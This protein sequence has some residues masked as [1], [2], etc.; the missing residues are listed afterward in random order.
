MD[1]ELPVAVGQRLDEDGVVEVA[2]GL[3]V[4]GDD[5]KAAEVAALRGLCGG[6]RIDG[7]CGGGGGFGEYVGGED[8]R[9]MM[10]A[11]H[12]LDVDAEGIGRAEDLDDAAFGGRPGEGKSVISTSTARPSRGLW[13]ASSSA[14]FQARCWVWASSPRTR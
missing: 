3:A 8:V 10:L 14:N 9:Q 13:V 6:E 1:L 2:G 4:D 7:L 12:D 11:D 5:G